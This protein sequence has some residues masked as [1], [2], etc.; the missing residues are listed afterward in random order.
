MLPWRRP[1]GKVAD[2]FAWQADPPVLKKQTIGGSGRQPV[3]RLG[4]SPTEAAG[5]AALTRPTRY[6]LQDTRVR[7]EV[8]TI[9]LGSPYIIHR[10]ECEKFAISMRRSVSFLQL[11]RD[12]RLSGDQALKLQ[13]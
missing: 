7:A 6:A 13:V 5:Y 9:H 2:G 3:T 1:D 12:V 11:L 4:G 8:I 10:S